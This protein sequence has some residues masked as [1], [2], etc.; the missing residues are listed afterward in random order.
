MPH[1]VSIS[2]P[3]MNV[4][5]YINTHMNE[6][7]RVC[8]PMSG[9]VVSTHLLLTRIRHKTIVP[10]INTTANQPSTPSLNNFCCILICC[11]QLI[12]F[13]HALLSTNSD[14]CC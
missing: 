10:K 6:P 3:I 5:E 12:L 4:D 9:S 8:L 14:K 2:S 1:C 13:L 7:P 11:C